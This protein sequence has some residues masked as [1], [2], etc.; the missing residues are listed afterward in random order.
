[1]RHFLLVAMVLTILAGMPAVA[2][3]SPQDTWT[4]V[5]ETI[6]EL[7]SN[8]LTVHAVNGQK[9]AVTLTLISRC[10]VSRATG[11]WISSPAISFHSAKS[12]VSI[13]YLPNDLYRSM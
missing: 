5:A 13:A 7:D 6:E 3:S 10:M 11:L 2:Q 8:V 12:G 1:M 4:R 9:Q